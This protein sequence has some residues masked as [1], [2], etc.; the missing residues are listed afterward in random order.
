MIIL[1]LDLAPDDGQNIPLPSQNIQ[2]Y[3]ANTEINRD[4]E[5]VTEEVI[6]Y[7]DSVDNLGISINFVAGKEIRTYSYYDT[8]ELLLIAGNPF[9]WKCVLKPVNSSTKL[10]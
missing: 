7:Y 8:D 2:K 9:F 5:K 3:Q 10:I 1:H 4:Y 6:E